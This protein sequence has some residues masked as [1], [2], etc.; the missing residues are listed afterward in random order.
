MIG[1]SSNGTIIF[2]DLLISDSA[3]ITI[4]K[5]PENAKPAVRAWQMFRDALRGVNTDAVL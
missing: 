5:G 2:S 3:G 1:Y 4:P